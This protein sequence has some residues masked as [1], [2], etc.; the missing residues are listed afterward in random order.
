M[1]ALL[2]AKK[3]SIDPITRLEGHGKIEIFLDEAGE[4]DKAYLQLPDLRGFEKFV[5][6]RPA[7]EMPQITSR[8][9]GVCPGAHHMA[10]TK[11]LDALF[12]VEPPLAARLIREVYY[13]LHF[14][15][16]HL[17]HFY[18]LGGPDFI[19]GP[20]APKTD[21]NILGV[22]DKVGVETGKEVIGIRHRARRLIDA[23]AGRAIHP[24]LGLPGG[25]AKQMTPEIQAELRAFAKDAVAFAQ[26]T[27]KVFDD[28]VWKNPVYR[29][30]ML[31]D[32]Y[33]CESYYMGMVDADGH[34]D[35]YDG[36]IRVV[37]Q[38][39]VEFTTFEPKDYAKVIAEHVEPWTYVKFPFLREV[40]W[41][42]LV[43]GPESGMYRVA[44]VAR[45]NVSKGMSTPLAAEQRSIYEDA[46]G[47]TVVH[48]VLANH[49]A[50]LV[51]VLNNAE[52]IQKLVEHEEFLSP[53]IRNMDLATP[54]EGV[55]IVE[56]PRGT[57]V[58]HYTS[59]ANGIITSANMIVASLANVAAMSMNIQSAAK[60]FIHKGQ[61]DEGLLNMVEMAFRTYDPCM[62]C[63]TH[64]LPGKMPLQIGL[65]QSGR[66]TRT[67]LRSS[68]GGMTETRHPSSPEVNHG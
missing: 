68:E 31:G 15:E 40:G 10:A 4:V 60:A 53:R 28:V 45:M 59:D 35:Y 21:R 65:H 19:V 32:V 7:E 38:Q 49:W 20:T 34:P 64:N 3:I 62:S 9:C 42:G 2:T 37:D 56:A 50:R 16:D 58:H 44:P 26:F 12:E 66:E 47:G 55:G 13:N 17:L 18:F 1:T 57:L 67:L 30:L 46:F 52:R 33:R 41:K 23:I 6:G 8:I 36:K 27:L 54:R 24:V 22:I 11:A 14:F 5:E 25:V 29:D 63:A 48:S 43:D 39:G 51:E 61:A